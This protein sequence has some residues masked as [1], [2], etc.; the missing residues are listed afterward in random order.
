MCRYHEFRECR[1]E[2]LGVWSKWGKFS[3]GVDV[4]CED[5]IL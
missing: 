1:V 4:E 3:W 2:Y 5:D